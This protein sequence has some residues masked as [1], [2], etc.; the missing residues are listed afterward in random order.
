[1]MMISNRILIQFFANRNQK[2][3]ERGIMMLPERWQKVID[4]NEQYITEKII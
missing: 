2:F 1:M 4:Q 3:Y